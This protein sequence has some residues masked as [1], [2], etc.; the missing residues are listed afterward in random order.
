[1][2]QLTIYLDD[3]TAKLLKSQVKSS[4]DS[5]SKWIADAIRKR[6]RTEWPP[7]VLALLGSWKDS[8]FPD[9]E[10]IRQGYGDDAPREEF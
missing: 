2:S 7:N 4:G 8:D 3:D 6:A 9:A 5:A 10:Q 1:M